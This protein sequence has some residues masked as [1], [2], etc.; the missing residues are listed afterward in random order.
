MTAFH[1][2]SVYYGEERCL[3]GESQVVVWAVPRA[4]G[5][6]GAS[7]LPVLGGWLPCEWVIA[8]EEGETLASPFGPG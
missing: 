8:C 5:A 6:A 3:P 7:E 4:D 1:L 2:E